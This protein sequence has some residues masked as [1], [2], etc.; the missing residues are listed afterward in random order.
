M[1]KLN[2]ILNSLKQMK[3]QRSKWK[4]VV[5]ADAI[6][7]ISNL[8]DDGKDC[9]VKSAKHLESL[10]LCGAENWKRYSEGCYG[11][12]VPSDVE[13]AC[14]YSTNTELKLTKCGQKRPNSRETWIEVQARG[15]FQSYRLATEIYYKLM[16]VK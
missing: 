7:I 14:K 3:L 15:L 1:V 13:I 9:E 2:Q 4:R 11:V 16:E 10:M 6:E 12:C 8:I 5:H